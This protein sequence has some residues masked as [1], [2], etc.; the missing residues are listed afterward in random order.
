[1]CAGKG[2]ALGTEAELDEKKPAPEEIM[3]SQLLW[4]LLPRK[5]NEQRCS[6]QPVLVVSPSPRFIILINRLSAL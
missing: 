4:Q 1:M 5:T 3:V 6:W 2:V